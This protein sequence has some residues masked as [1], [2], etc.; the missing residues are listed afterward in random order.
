MPFSCLRHLPLP[1]ARS[2]CIL[3]TFL[4]RVAAQCINI[5]SSP[6][7]PTFSPFAFCALVFTT[8]NVYLRASRGYGW[9]FLPYTYI[10][11]PYCLLS[12]T[13]LAPFPLYSS[14]RS[15]QHLIVA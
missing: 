1:P 13:P 3:L 11:S 9:S 14:F 12:S 4:A 7:S 10:C 2:S 6:S 5:T 15:V 8:T